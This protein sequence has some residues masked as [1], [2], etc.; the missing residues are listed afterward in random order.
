L[1]ELAHKLSDK[2]GYK[3]YRTTKENKAKQQLRY[4]F[5]VGKLEQYKWFTANNIPTIEYTT[6]DWEALQWEDQGHVVFGRE[7]LNAS[8]GK[9]IHIFDGTGDRLQHP[10]CLVYTKYKQKKREFR[11]HVLQETVVYILEKRLRKDWDGSRESKIRNLAN[12]WV[13]CKPI[14]TI[15]E[16]LEELA[17]RASKVSSSDFKGVDII[18]NKKENKLFVL[19]VNSAPG[20]QGTTLDKYINEIIKHEN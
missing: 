6:S 15:P 16:G 8:C 4:G 13:F 10:S 11:V 2:L 17:V 9:G 3:V 18:Y 5:G 7:C 14:E 19:E 1:R 12:G 20:M